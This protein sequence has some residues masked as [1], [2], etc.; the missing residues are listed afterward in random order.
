[1]VLSHVSFR[2]NAPL[3]KSVLTLAKDAT[4]MNDDDVSSIEKC[5]S[6]HILCLYTVNVGRYASFQ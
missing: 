5:S 4:E 6:L 3:D 1:M 2:T